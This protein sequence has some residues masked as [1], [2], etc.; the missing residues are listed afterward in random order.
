MLCTATPFFKFKQKY[1]EYDPCFLT[2]FP[3]LMTV[4]GKDG[5][6][7]ITNMRPHFL[8]IGQTFQSLCQVFGFL[9]SLELS[10]KL[11]RVFAFRKHGWV[12]QT[13]G[14][15]FQILAQASEVL[16]ENQ[17]LCRVCVITWPILSQS[18]TVIYDVFMSLFDKKIRPSQFEQLSLIFW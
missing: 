5:P 13:L 7:Y 2:I 10:L 14:R 16:R 11:G 17:K 9:L 1:Q 18:A 6:C 4:M 8:N 12:F 3:F 15:A